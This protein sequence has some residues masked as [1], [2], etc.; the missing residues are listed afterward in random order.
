MSLL[1]ALEEGLEEIK[2]YLRSKGLQTVNLGNE[3][4][5]VDAVVY[6][7]RSL[8]EI[9]A[10]QILSSADSLQDYAGGNSYGVLLVN[11]RDKTPQEVYEIIKNRVY[12]RFI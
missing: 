1:V 7:D 11:A 4:M 8:S 9:Q 10:E 2:E 6:K 12:E 5:A 3:N